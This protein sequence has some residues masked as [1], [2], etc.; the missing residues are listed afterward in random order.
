MLT[1]CIKLFLLP[2]YNMSN[3]VI[4]YRPATG[5]ITTSHIYKSSKVYAYTILCLYEMH[6]QFHGHWSSEWIRVS[7]CIETPSQCLVI[8]YSVKL[9]VTYIQLA[10]TAISIDWVTPPWITKTLMLCLD[11]PRNLFNCLPW[12]NIWQCMQRLII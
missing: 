5:K 9:K 6:I 12:S 8:Q 4:Q 7:V 11:S 10:C 2:F 1:D 3:I